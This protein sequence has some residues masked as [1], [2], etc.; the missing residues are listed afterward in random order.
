MPTLISH[1]DRLNHLLQSA[2]PDKDSPPLLDL[3]KLVCEMWAVSRMAA[4][5]S[6]KLATRIYLETCRSVYS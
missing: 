4:T 5:F 1:A 3:L 6:Q 2:R